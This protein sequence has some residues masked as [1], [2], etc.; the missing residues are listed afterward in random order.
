MRKRQVANYLKTIKERTP[1]VCVI[2][3]DIPLIKEEQ[4]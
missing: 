3:N 4:I 2:R 1:A